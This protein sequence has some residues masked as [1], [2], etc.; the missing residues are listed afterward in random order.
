MSPTIVIRTCGFPNQPWCLTHTW[1]EETIHGFPKVIRTKAKVTN[2]T[3]WFLFPA[4]QPFLY[5]IK[6]WFYLRIV[7]LLGLLLT[8][9]N[10]DSFIFSKMFIQLLRANIKKKQKQNY[11]RFWHP[12]YRVRKLVPPPYYL[13]SFLCLCA[14]AILT[15]MTFFCSVRQSFFFHSI[16]PEVYRIRQTLVESRG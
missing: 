4:A 16:F 8:L 5:K 12:Y 1:G 15:R 14:V 10:S 3:C 13:N 9:Q 2:A 7:L 6:S 11:V